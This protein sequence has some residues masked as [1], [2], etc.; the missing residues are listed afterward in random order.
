MDGWMDRWIFGNGWIWMNGLI[1]GRR[2]RLMDG[3][4][5]RWMKG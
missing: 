1:D 4:M 5:D 2:D 3:R